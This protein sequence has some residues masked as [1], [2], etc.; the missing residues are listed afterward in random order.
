M[1]PF[2]PRPDPPLAM[3]TLS[4]RVAWLLAACSSSLLAQSPVPY[5]NVDLGANIVYPAP[6]SAYSAATAQAG[7]WNARSATIT[8]PVALTDVNGVVTAITASHTGQGIDFEFQN[9]TTPLN[10]D[11]ERLLD[12]VQDIG[13]GPNSTALW[14]IGPLPAGTYRVTAYASAPDAPTFG[15]N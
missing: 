15:T 13:A 10:S 1:A 11:V 6:S 9:S 7:F 14:T 8:S 5:F 12:D 3:R 4:L 2:P